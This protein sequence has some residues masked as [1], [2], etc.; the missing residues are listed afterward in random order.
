MT[1][2]LEDASQSWHKMHRLNDGLSSPQE[3]AC[4]SGC[5]VAFRRRQKS[6]QKP[7]PG[8]RRSSYSMPSRFRVSTVP[9][10][11]L[12]LNE[13]PARSSGSGSR[14]MTCRIGVIGAV[15]WCRRSCNH[16]LNR[17]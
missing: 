3:G 7:P 15:C 17:L 10:R 4:G 12:A 1:R 13:H 9:G 6:C 14:W 16:Q 5:D 11:S 2:N 8:R